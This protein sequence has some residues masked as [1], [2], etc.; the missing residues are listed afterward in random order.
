VLLISR[1]G[2]VRLTKWYSPYTQKERTKVSILYCFLSHSLFCMPLLLFLCSLHCLLIF[3]VVRQF[4]R[5][6][7]VIYVSKQRLSLR[8]CTLINI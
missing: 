6:V 5:V 8:Q 2:K 1:Q 4:A 7:D 3:V